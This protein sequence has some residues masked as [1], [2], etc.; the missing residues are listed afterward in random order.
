[1]EN[2][3]KC[4]EFINWFE[5][6]VSRRPGMLGSVGDISAMFYIVD[7]I[8]SI[9]L[10]DEVLPRRLSWVEF[11]IEHG[12]IRESKVVPVEDG[13]DFERFVDL[14]RRY[15]KWVEDRRAEDL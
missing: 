5:D 6:T 13:W 7:N 8:N 4:R 11:L 9:L 2:H 12:L 1:M 15:L 3:Q 10:F 14:R